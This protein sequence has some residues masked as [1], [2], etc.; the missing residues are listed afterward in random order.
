[1]NIL[2]VLHYSGF[3]G[4]NKSLLTLMTLLRE[5]YS[6]TP[7]VLLPNKGVVCHELDK[8]GIEFQVFHYYWWVNNDHGIFQWF[9]NKRKQFI[10]WRRVKRISSLFKGRDIDLVYTNSIC[11]NMGYLIAKQM[12][13]PH[14]WHAR[15]SLDQF[16]LSLSL[17]L[18]KSLAIW[19][20]PVNKKYL[21]ISDYM[22]DFYREYLPVD[23]MVRVYNGVSLPTGISRSKKNELKGRL[24]IC[25]MGVLS[26]QK[27]QLELLKALRILLLRSIEADVWLLGTG[28]PAYATILEDYVKQEGFEQCVHLVGHTD[29]VFQILQGMNL[30]VVAARD[31]AFGR[32]TVEFMLMRMPVI[33]SRSGA[34]AELIEPGV[35]GEVYPLGDPIALADAIEQY[36]RNPELLDIHGRAGELSAKQFFSAEKNAEAVYEQIQ[37]VIN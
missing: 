15:E 35:S 32:V 11:V 36:V 14:I 6:V 12:G 10:N 1:M 37:N 24:Q 3:Y 20:S 33:A 9:L 29:D 25:C 21:L 23:R 34:N 16:S 18:S 26:E 5:H 28:V 19:A 31:E 17:S 27:N 2:F 13:L 8:A 30:G 4:A 22:M 7:V